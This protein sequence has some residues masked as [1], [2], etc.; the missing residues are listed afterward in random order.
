[1]VLL[2]QGIQVVDLSQFNR[3]RKDSSGLERGNGFVSIAANESSS[4]S[5]RREQGNCF[6]DGRNTKILWILDAPHPPG[7]VTITGVKVSSPSETFQQTFP[8]AGS[9]T[10]GA[11]YPSIVN[12]PTPGCW[13]I[14]FGRIASVLFWVTGN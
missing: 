13:Q 2:N 14:Q 1:M 10:P 5:V 4:S 8:V 7:E 3:L 12:V 9:A 11:N 6:L